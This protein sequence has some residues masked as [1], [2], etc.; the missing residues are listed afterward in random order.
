MSNKS[1]RTY[2]RFDCADCRKS[3]GKKT[4]DVESYMVHDSVWASAGMEPLGGGLCVN[5]LEARLGRSLTGAD[6]PTDKPIN[7]PGVMRDTPQLFQLKSDAW[8]LPVESLTPGAG[9]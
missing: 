3:V 2:R 1:R 9:L 4:G 6:F 5:C 7:F 8:G